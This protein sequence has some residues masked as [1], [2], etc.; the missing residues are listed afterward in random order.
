[1]NY[2]SLSFYA[3]FILFFLIYYIIPQ[4]YRYIVI[5]LG[6]WLFYGYSDPKI[7]SVLLA[8]TIVTYLGGLIIKARP[9]K[10][11]LCCFFLIN[12][13][14]LLVFKYSNFMIQNYN[15]I[16]SR[17]L[18]RA[19][20]ASEIDI[21][22]PIGLSFIIF[23]S[24]TYLTDIYHKNIEPERNIIRYGA[25]VAFF[26]T[27]LSGP[28]QKSRELIPQIKCPREFDGE[29]AKKGTLL[30]IWG[31]FEKTMVAN[32]LSTI[33]NRV[34]NDY[35]SFN[36]AYY[37]IAAVCFSLYIY[38][39]F[40]SYSDMARGIAQIMGIDIKKNFNN[41]YLSTTTSEFWNR[42][43]MSLN[44]WFVENIYIPLGGNRKG[45]LRKYFNVAVVFFVSGIWHGANWHF[46]A[47]GVVN[48]V[49]VIIGQA[50]KPVKKY[51]C[52]KLKIDENVESILLCR[53]AIVFWL[54]SVTWVFF[55]NGVRESL[56]IVKR[57]IMFSP[58]NF[59]D[60]GLLAISG[61]NT[62]TFISIIAAVLFCVMQL[63]RQ[64]EHEVYLKYSRQP[65]VVQCICAAI[66]I[67]IC[68]F[69]ICST[70]PDVNTQ[71][72]YFQF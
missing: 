3:F 36:S 63:K 15:S 64:N 66:V 61:T 6:S 32:N 9:G 20:M 53:R 1:M 62:A 8:V 22:L 4:R 57:I 27:I 68:V 33:V 24:C 34:F 21:L 29:A 70:E 44:S 19:P 50:L 28:I 55:R 52:T 45:T 13:C 37:I 25:F 23:Q 47:W 39:D 7:L 46:V 54:I 11:T 40:S 5:F 67:C 38:A 30:F 58:L 60:P 31:L 35:L 10:S 72:L 49:L 12:I 69:A 51:I 65:L 59:F 17:L 18:P 14:I 42:W 43:H 48:G 41:P 71:F 16:V 56:Y 26:P 2:L